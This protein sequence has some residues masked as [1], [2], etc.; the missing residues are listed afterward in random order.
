MNCCPR[1]ARTRCRARG[2]ATREVVREAVRRAVRA[3]VRVSCGARSRIAQCSSP[4]YDGRD[5]RPPQSCRDRRA[6]PRRRPARSLS[7]QLGATVS[8]PMALAEHGV[9][10]VFVDLPNS[11][12]ELM[13]PLGE[14]S[15]IAAFLER[16]PDGRHSPSLLRG[17][18]H[19]GRGRQLAGTGA[20]AHRRRRA[21][22]RRARQAGGLPSPEGLSSA[23]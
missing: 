21:E 10:I 13:E 4:S 5:A 23:P 1:R 6:G 3:G 2:D 20:R 22:D 12:I 7:R 18:G 19:P 11:K 9:T 17:A 16:N 8:D 15:P 14:A